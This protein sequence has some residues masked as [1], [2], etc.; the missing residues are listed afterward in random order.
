MIYLVKYKADD[1]I[2]GY[3]NTKKEFDN[4][5]KEHNKKRK[6]EGEIIE[7]KDEFE[8]IRVGDLSQWE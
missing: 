5:L 8:L 4:W 2:E 6:K 3:V 7:H 1:T